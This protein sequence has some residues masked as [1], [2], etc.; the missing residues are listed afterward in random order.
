MS[1]R[2]NNHE[3]QTQHKAF[4]R[5]R[6]KVLDDIELMQLPSTVFE[7]RDD[8]QYFVDYSFHDSGNW[9]TPPFTCIDATADDFTDEQSAAFERVKECWRLECENNVILDRRG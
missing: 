3:R 9:R 7:T 1:F 8:W 4:V 2:Q 6:E 5:W